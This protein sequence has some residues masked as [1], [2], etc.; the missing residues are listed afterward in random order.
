VTRGIREGRRI[1][2]ARTTVGGGDGRRGDGRYGLEPAWKT[3]ACVT[4]AS[5][6]ARP[7]VSAQVLD[8]EILEDE[9]LLDN[10]SKKKERRDYWTLELHVFL[11]TL[12]FPLQNVF[13]LS[14]LCHRCRKDSAIFTLTPVTRG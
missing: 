14:T 2:P 10:F 12:F 7:T 9:S 6:S 4:V 1:R 5:G 13:V 11:A 3:A 8:M